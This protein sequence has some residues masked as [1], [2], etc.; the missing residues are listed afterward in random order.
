[1]FKTMK[2]LKFKYRTEGSIKFNKLSF[3]AF[4][5]FYEFILTMGHYRLPQGDIY[6]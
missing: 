1:M 2:V 6:G 4:V 3:Y 5:L